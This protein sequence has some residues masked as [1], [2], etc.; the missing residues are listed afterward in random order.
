VLRGAVSTGFRAP[1]LQQSFYSATATNFINVGGSLQ[2]FDV[3][4]APV[5][6]AIAIALGSSPLQP[7]KSLNYSAGFALEP[8][9]SLAITVDA[10]RIDIDDRIVLSENFTGAAVQAKLAPLGAA[11]ARYFTNAIDTRTDGID[12]VMNYGLNLDRLGFVRLTA[13]Y[14]HNRTEVTRVSTTP[15]ELGDQRE[16]LFGRT[17]EGRIEEAQPRDNVLVSANYEYRAFGFVLRSQRFGEVTSR[18]AP[19]SVVNDQTFGAKWVTDVSASFR[20]VDRVTFTVGADNVLDVYPDQ[21][22]KPGS[23]TASGNANFGIFPYNQFSP[24]GFNGR[25]LF[26]RLSYGL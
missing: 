12:V 7:E 20:A 14:N 18:N 9:R 11:A 24:F 8:L 5:G 13:G 25:F 15:P 23:A 26:L 4:T 22:D 21:N 10:Y 16:A 17:E 1:S 2:P 19:S 6:S 3:K